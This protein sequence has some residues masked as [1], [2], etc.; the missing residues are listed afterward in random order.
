MKPAKL[1]LLPCM[2][3]KKKTRPDK[4]GKKKKGGEEEAI[5]SQNL[6]DLCLERKKNTEPPHQ[7]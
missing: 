3:K 1:L 5:F 7:E 6:G 2:S 4:K